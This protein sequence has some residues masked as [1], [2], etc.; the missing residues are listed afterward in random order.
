VILSLG[1]I[2]ADFLVRTSEP[3][4][5]PGSSL[6]RD[7]LRTSGG[8]AA[9]LAVLAT[10]LGAEVRLLGCVGDDDLAAQA[11]AGPLEEGVDLA[12]VRRRPG[13]TRYASVMVPPDGAKTIVL[14]TGAN[15]A[16]A[17]DAAAVADDVRASPD[18]T[19]VVVSLEVPAEVVEGALRA[20]RERGFTT[21][22]D[23]APSSRLDS[24]L[25]SLVDQLTPDH[26]EAAELTGADTST[27]DGAVEAAAALRDKGAA[28]VHVKLAD[29]GCVVAAEDG[30][31]AVHAPEVDPVDATGA[32]DAFAG[33]LA[34]ALHAGR[35]TEDA[36][37]VAVAASTIAVTAFGSQ[38][39]YPTPD[40]LDAMLGRVR[41]IAQPSSE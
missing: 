38:E 11:L 41:A 2:N 20:A 17:D 28:I 26:S 25:L 24:S 37:R 32:G 1:S 35:S 14:F 6:A 8:K 31:T 10:R 7:L 29:G 5:G 23:P 19:V 22:L 34:W 30:V 15:D 18:G 33:A 40:P 9:N 39:A 4:D 13:P 16:W 3:P 36:A 21:V 12:G 27:V